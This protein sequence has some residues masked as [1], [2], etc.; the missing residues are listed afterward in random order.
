LIYQ[1]FQLLKPLQ[2]LSLLGAQRILKDPW[3]KLYF[4]L[5]ETNALDFLDEL[6][7]SL[8]KAFYKMG[9]KIGKWLVALSTLGKMMKKEE[10]LCDKLEQK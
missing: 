5:K 6:G 7:D 4:K 9:K 8:Y 2:I 3:L 10:E 1:H